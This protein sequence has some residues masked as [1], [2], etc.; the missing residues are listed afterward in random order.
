MGK[1]IISKW[2]KAGYPYMKEGAGLPSW[3]LPQ[4]SLELVADELEDS[5][6]LR[7]SRPL[8]LADSVEAA[9]DRM[10]D[11]SVFTA[12]AWQQAVSQWPPLSQVRAVVEAYLEVADKIAAEPGRLR[13]KVDPAGI[14]R[15]VAMLLLASLVPQGKRAMKEI[16]GILD[17]SADQPGELIRAYAGAVIDGDLSRV[18]DVVRCIARHRPWARWL[19]ELQRQ[20]AAMK[21][22]P[23]LIGVTPLL[24]SELISVL[25]LMIKEEHQGE[26]GR[27]YPEHRAS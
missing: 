8:R 21:C 24:S 26:F 6:I 3:V 9:H 10:P 2:L 25:T 12:E 19:A 1:Q 15:S 18:K 23:R 7:L 5:G 11:P 17:G 13:D 22:H 16:A 4:R 14:R 20:T 27:D